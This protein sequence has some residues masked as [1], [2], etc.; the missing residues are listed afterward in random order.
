MSDIYIV[1]ASIRNSFGLLL[2]HLGGWIQF[3]VVLAEDEKQPGPHLLYE[4]WATLGAEP[5]VAELLA[6]DLR[7]QWANGQ[8]QIAAS[9]ATHGD[10]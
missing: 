8:L 6:L 5:E 3:R 9:S 10:L 4:L 2:D 1:V 7:L